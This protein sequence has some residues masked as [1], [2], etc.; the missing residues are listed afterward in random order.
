MK[1]YHISVLLDLSKDSEIVLAN[2]VGLAKAIGGVVEVFHV[3]SPT[4][5]YKDDT[6]AKVNLEV[7][8]SKFRTKG[9][10]P[11]NF[12][13]KKGAVKKRVLEYVSSEQPDFLVLGKTRRFSSVFGRSITDLVIKHTDHTN[14]LLLGKDDELY[15]FKEMNL[16]IFGGGIKE[17]GLQII[18][19]LNPKDDNPVRLFHIK[20]D[21]VSK[22]KKYLG[23]KTISY[24]FSKGTNA[25][26][27]MVNYV[28][29]TNIQL[30]CVS[31]EEGK[32][33]WFKTSPIKAVIRKSKIPL[34]ILA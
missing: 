16:G 32:H 7:M 10:L 8:V 22:T 19:N 34:M 11:I 29:K 21:K 24:V 17:S 14:I 23:Q 31:K 18:K 25:L 12:I 3:K 15:S 13:I 27:S 9:A 4:A 26:D 30:L 6:S 28:T 33:L 2:A 20:K 5:F 1:T